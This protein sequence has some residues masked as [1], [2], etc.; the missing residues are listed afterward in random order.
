MLVKD[1][2]TIIEEFAP[3]SLQESYDN[4][5]L[6]CGDPNNSVSSIL[7]TTDI[8]EEVLDEAISEGYVGAKNQ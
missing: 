5:G 2:T 1:I 3:L 8:T 6:L 7:L 4:A